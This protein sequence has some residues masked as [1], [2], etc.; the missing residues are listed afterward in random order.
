MSQRTLVLLKPDTVRRG[1]VGEVLSRFEKVLVAEL[2]AGQLALLLRAEFLV[3]AQR[4]AKTEGQPFRIEE[5]RARVDALLE[6][7]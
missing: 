7:N 1:L 3:D 5:I 2:N 4:L 6:E